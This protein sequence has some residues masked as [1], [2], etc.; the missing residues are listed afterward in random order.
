VTV[1]VAS[2]PFHLHLESFVDPEVSDR[3]VAVSFDVTY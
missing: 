3:D 2:L 1:A